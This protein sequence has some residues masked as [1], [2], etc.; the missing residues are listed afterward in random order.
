V[1]ALTTHPS[2][3]RAAAV[4]AREVP[5][6]AV[7]GRHLPAL[8]GL[9]AVAVAGVLA[10]HLGFGWASGGY[11]GVDLFFVLSGF[12][13]TSL[14]L[15]EWV[16]TGT[17]RLAAFWA[18]RA[19]RLLPALFV[20]LCVLALFVVCM[21]RFGPPGWAAQIDLSQLRGDAVATLLYVA[22]W[23]A[24]FAHQSY[25][26]QF[27]APSPL[28]H[29]W[30]LA[31]EEQFYLVWPLVLVGL[32]AVWRRSRRGG[33]GWRRLGLAVTV[34][35][36]L[37]SAALM[38]ALYHPGSDPTRVY[39][40]TDTRMFDLLAGA[41]V[42]MLV[43]A[44][45]QPGRR[46]RAVLHAASPVAAAGL[47]V[48]WVVGGTSGG[49]PRT[50]MFD[51]G[52]LACAVLAALVVAD[53]R[54]L[55]RGPLAV[56]LS[57]PPL[58]WVG[59]VSYGIY[60]W[61]W[62]IFVF[63]DTS[64]TGLAGAG[65]DLVR[66]ACTLGAATASYYLVERPIRRYRF[67]GWPRFAVAP[68]AAAVTGVVVVIG[69]LPAVVVGAAP[70]AGGAAA[71]AAVMAAPGQ[72]VPGA[73]GIGSEV[74]IALPA[75]GPGDPLRVTVLGDSVARAA[76]PAIA[77]ALDATGDVRVAD[78]TI[79]GFG[80]TTDPIWRTSLPTVV[81]SHRAQLVLAT[82]SWDDSC[83][84]SSSTPLVHHDTNDCA[85][86]HPVA[87]KRMLEAAVRLMLGPGGASGIVFLQF[88]TTGPVTGS[89]PASRAAMDTERT[90][91]EAAWD[92]VARSLTA[93]FP[94]RVMYLP[95][96]SSVLLHGK[97]SAWLPPIDDPGAGANQWVRVR[98]VDNVHLCPAGAARYAD[99]VLADVTAAFALPP[100]AATW[101]EGRWTADRRYDTP[102]GSCPADHPPG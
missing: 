12:L 71:V 81:A 65:L 63:L 77:A 14:L 44:R 6:T 73:G 102:P 94:G 32:L 51:G 95:V 17:V 34:V 83:S 101:P 76:E 87:Y 99:A 53:V 100:A 10:Y 36:G 35:A 72:P 88:P 8:D 33:E 30:S 2:T 19:R 82:W 21:G 52:F 23:Y 1:A 3:A 4:R 40:G 66:I 50:W 69:T 56:V 70:A 18:R 43:A 54:Q 78:A 37:G 62:P 15:E 79:D 9:R 47:G 89:T 27:S 7:T 38:A 90:A 58:R 48:C 24:V 5:P 59:T 85:L 25:F 26:A 16:L 84:A 45:P 29:T 39:Y 64:R 31:I 75:F 67:H 61:H 60:L 55:D 57:S 49:L 96:A 42:A 98:T 20:L 11:L 68:F 93:V 92:R 91:G 74:P 86:E 13:I 80:L 46:S 41:S 28:E 22:N 97:F